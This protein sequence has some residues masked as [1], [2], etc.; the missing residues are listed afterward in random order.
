MDLSKNRCSWCMKDEL[1]M[2]YHDHEWGTP[3]HDDKIH[4][5]YLALEA[6]QAGLSWY[7]ILKRKSGYTTAF[8]NWDIDLIEKFNESKVEELLKFEGIIRNR[9]KIEAVIHNVSPFK[10]IQKEFGSFDHYIWGFVDGKPIVNNIESL[11]D[12][13]A[14]TPLS[15]VIS[16]DLKKRGFKFIGATTTYAYMQAI[17]L[18][19][20]HMND[21]WKK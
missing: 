13:P 2:A 21:C 10:T 19:N 17:G 8:V 11:G 7:T 15:D 4:F 12:Y 3:V 9:K 18:I 14:T 5:E 20:D 6:A 16:K 1:Y